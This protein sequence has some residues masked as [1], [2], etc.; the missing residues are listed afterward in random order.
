M[1][2]LEMF[3]PPQTKSNHRRGCIRFISNKIP[4]A[5]D[6]A[7][8]KNDISQIAREMEYCA[9][10]LPTSL[11]NLEN[12]LDVLRDSKE[13]FISK[14]N[15]MV[16]TQRYITITEDDLLLFLNYQ[17]KIGNILFF[18]DIPE[19]IIL[20]PDWLVSCFR[21]LVCDDRKKYW[22]LNFCNDMLQLDLKGK[23]SD[24]LMTELFQKQP[25]LKFGQHIRKVMETFKI[26]VQPQ[27]EEA[28]NTSYYMPSVIKTTTTL[29]EIIA[30]NPELKCSCR[31]P[32]LVLEF[33]FLPIAYLNSIMCNYISK[34]RVFQLKSGDPAIFNGTAVVYIDKERLQWL[35]I[36]ISKN[37]ISLQIC[38]YEQKIVEHESIL[39]EIRSLI[40]KLKGQFMQNLSYEIKAKC[41]TGNCNSS[42]GRISRKEMTSKRALYFCTDHGKTHSKRE[43]ENSWFKQPDR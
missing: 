27:F 37:A 36:R 8:L 24:S 12:A 20:Q 1:K 4:L 18:E 5:K 29:A 19:Y 32:W 31:T 15:M 2:F 11:I 38:S 39:T 30:K 34:Y 43:I 7:S 9:E 28:V 3:G 23:L 33:K 22:D 13:F 21:C 25:D 41:N 14:Q 40:E 26:I 17:H 6:I 42:L 35:I 10:T 16:L